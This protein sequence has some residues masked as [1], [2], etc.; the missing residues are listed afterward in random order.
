MLRIH[1]MPLKWDGSFIM[2]SPMGKNVETENEGIKK[3]IP[4]TLAAISFFRA[5]SF[6]LGKQA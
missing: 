2:V 4:R 1:S 6:I 3:A 5:A